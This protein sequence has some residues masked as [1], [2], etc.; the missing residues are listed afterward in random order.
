[1]SFLQ[2]KVRQQQKLCHVRS[3]IRLQHLGNK[4]GMD[5][6]LKCLSVEVASDLLDGKDKSSFQNAIRQM[7]VAEFFLNYKEMLNSS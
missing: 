5:L 3:A 4:L 1:M 6:L 7:S 2:Q